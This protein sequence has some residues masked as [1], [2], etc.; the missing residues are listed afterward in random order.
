MKRFRQALYPNTAASK[1]TTRNSTPAA[2]MP[3]WPGDDEAV[4]A[5]NWRRTREPRLLD[6][7]APMPWQVTGPYLFGSPGRTP[8]LLTAA[9]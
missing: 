6:P 5:E 4:V 8:G 9:K 1:P 2:A 3:R 7:S